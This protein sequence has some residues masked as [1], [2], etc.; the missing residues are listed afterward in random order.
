MKIAKMLRNRKGFTLVE[1]MVVVVIIGVLAGI[2]IPMYS[3]ATE[4]AANAAHEANIRTIEGAIVQYRSVNGMNTDPSM[5]QLEGTYIK[6]GLKVPN[7]Y[8]S[9]PGGTYTITYTNHVPT[10]GTAAAAAPGG[11]S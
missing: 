10:V 6:A 9:N 8:S 1:L 5:A 4:Q 3:K 11:G 7:G 2:A